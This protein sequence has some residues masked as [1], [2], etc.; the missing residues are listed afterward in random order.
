MVLG[1]YLYGEVVLEYVDL[2]VGAHG[3][4]QGI[5]NFES[6]VVGMVEDAEFG[7]SS[8]AVKIETSVLVLVEVDAPPY[9]LAYLLGCSFHDHFYG[10]RIAEPV[11]GD[12][13][14]VYMFVEIVDLKIGYRGYSALS[15]GCVGFVE[16]GFADKCH[17][18]AAGC[19]F[20]SKAH[21]G[22]SGTYYKIVIFVCHDNAVLN[23]ANLTKKQNNR[24][25]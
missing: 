25:I 8:F 11:A 10:F 5:L 3:G 15:E 12:H 23:T 6:G 4:D 13:G 22:Y 2:R 16:G 14:I 20:Q 7:V 21:S 19:Y 18:A 9:K 17:L 1:D 24:N